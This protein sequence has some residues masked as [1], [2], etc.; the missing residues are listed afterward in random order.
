[1]WNGN[2]SICLY[3]VKL[4]NWFMHIH[5]VY[6]Y[7]V[8]TNEMFLGFVLSGCNLYSGYEWEVPRTCI[9]F[10]TG[11]LS[12][13]LCPWLG[14]ANFKSRL[15]SSRLLPNLQPRWFSCW[16]SSESVLICSFVRF[17]GAILSWPALL[18]LGWCADLKIKW[19]GRSGRKVW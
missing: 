14:S 9:I 16:Y 10:K 1:M 6:L 2:T 4:K 15:G 5:E 3:L 13:I 8:Y 18:L 12:K 7:I 17:W 19:N 11:I